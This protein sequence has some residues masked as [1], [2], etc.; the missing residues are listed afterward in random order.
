MLKTRVVIQK[1]TRDTLAAAASSAA[2]KT[3]DDTMIHAIIHSD[4][5]PADKS[6]DRVVEEVMAVTGAAFETTASALRLIL[7]NVYT[8]DEILGRLR[9]ELDS[10]STGHSE[11]I[12]LRQ[13]YQLLYFTAVLTEGMR[14]SAVVALRAARVT[15]KDL[16]YDK[17]QIPAGTPVE[18]TTLLIHT[19]EAMYSDLMR[20]N[21]RSVGR[22]HSRGTNQGPIRALWRRDEDISWQTVSPVPLWSSSIDFC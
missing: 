7:Y 15:D 17:W 13:L 22:F 14:L 3:V 6:L 8:N 4:L 11:P 5:P 18:M 21:T 10:V 1:K 19:D 9:E 16:L 12:F 2:D 20:F